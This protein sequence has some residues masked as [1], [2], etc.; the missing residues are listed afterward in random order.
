MNELNR[1]LA[2][3]PERWLVLV[4]ALLPVLLLVGAYAFGLS[5]GDRWHGG[6]I[7]AA[8]VA[9]GLVGAGLY[10]GRRV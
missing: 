10:A 9:L 3:L 5:H 6:G 4:A 2:E 1:R 7:A 8:I